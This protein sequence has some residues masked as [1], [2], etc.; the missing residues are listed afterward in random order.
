MGSSITGNY[1]PIASYSTGPIGLS[2][3][4]SD[5]P[6]ASQRHPPW[7]GTDQAARA[8]RCTIDHSSQHGPC[9]A[10]SCRDRG[11]RPFLLKVG[12]VDVHRAYYHRGP[13][14]RRLFS[15]ETAM[16]S[17]FKMERSLTRKKEFAPLPYP[18]LG[19]LSTAIGGL[20]RGAAGKLNLNGLPGNGGFCFWTWWGLFNSFSSCGSRCYTAWGCLSKI[21]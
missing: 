13:L 12:R 10:L 14:V 16:R 3:P 18:S 8:I 17:P 4:R 1:Y 11:C 5:S 19:P 20:K 2:H 6:P 7:E 21:C 15:Y 9:R